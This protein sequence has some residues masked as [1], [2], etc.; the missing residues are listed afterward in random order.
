MRPESKKVFVAMSGGVDSSTAAALLLKEKFDCVGLFMITNDESHQAQKDAEKVCRKL[1]IELCVLDFRDEFEEII[2]YLCDEYASG[3]TPNP[4]VQCN[5]VIKFD[6]LWKYAKANGGS[7]IATG[8]YA[9][10]MKTDGRSGLYE[11][12]EHAKDQSYVLSM[13]D[14]EILDYI[15]LPMGQYDKQTVRKLAGEFELGIEDKE[16]SQEICFL[17]DGDYAKLVEDRHPD[18][19]HTGKIVDTAGNILGE[20]SGVHH[21]TI[22]QRRGL[23][24]ALGQP[25]Y[26]VKIDLP[27]NTVTLG[28][29][30]ELLSKKLSATSVNWLIDKPLGSFRARVKIRYNNAG[31]MGEVIPEGD[32]ITVEFE[33]AVSAITPGQAAVF[34]IPENDLWR[35][36]GGAWIDGVGNN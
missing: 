36:A 3:R 34:Y 19:A 4:C 12:R 20:H 18:I 1:G 10:I 22:G 23:G 25:A 6:K 13:I 16:D 15:I 5:K 28:S 9:Q 11:A 2:S 30:E 14:R 33:E 21:Y 29:K 24:V 7:F 8:H 26:V 31:Q 35:V 27:A 32:D 17:P